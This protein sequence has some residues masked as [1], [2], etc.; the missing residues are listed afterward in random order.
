MRRSSTAV[1]GV[2]LVL[3]LAGP[4]AADHGDIHPVLRN[5]RTWFRCTGATK[6]QNASVAQGQ[7]PSRTT[8]APAQSVQ[9]GAGCGF[10]DNILAVTNATG[11]VTGA[12]WEGTFTGN[13]DALTVDGVERYAGDVAA[14]FT[15]SSTRA[16][17]STTFTFQRLRYLTEDGAGEVERTVRM[18]VESYNETQ[19]AWVFDT[20][21]VPAGIEFNP[22]KPSGTRITV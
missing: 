6:L 22:A 16:S 18:Q 9:Q 21:E 11:T 19:S 2:V 15:D 17:E 13:L 1:L 14:A 4:A 8:T 5:E 10:Y 7:I 12:V 3:A 20:T